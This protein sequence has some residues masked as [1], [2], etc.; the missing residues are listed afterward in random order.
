MVY[1]GGIVQVPAK[2]GPGNKQR[3]TWQATFPAGVTQNLLRLR[4]DPMEDVVLY[5]QLT[6]DSTETA[7]LI[8]TQT[9]NDVTLPLF[10]DV[11]PYGGGSIRLGGSVNLSIA[12]DNLVG[13]FATIN[14]WVDPG[15]LIQHCPPISRS[16]TNLAQGVPTFVSPDAA[17]T[18]WS[19]PRRHKLSFVATNTCDL[20][21]ID[22]AGNNVGRVT[23]NPG[24]ANREIELVHPPKTRLRV[25]NTSAVAV[26]MTATWHRP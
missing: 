24:T 1:Q 11:G 3:Y 14:I 22:T 26:G 10:L 13:G 9:A 20:E 23:Y 17:S 6:N 18:G 5:Y 2:A 21:F 7:T 16:I 25:N 12:V 4:H 19:P 15:A 8:A